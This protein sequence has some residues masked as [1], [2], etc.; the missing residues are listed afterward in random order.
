MHSGDFI[1]R[2]EEENR[3]GY[4]FSRYRRKNVFNRGVDSPELYVDMYLKRSERPKNFRR[5][6]LYML[7]LTRVPNEK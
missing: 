2:C 5:Y 1:K 4:L 7:D 6:L 3:E